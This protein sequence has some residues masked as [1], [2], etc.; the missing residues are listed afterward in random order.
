LYQEIAMFYLRRQI[1]IATVLLCSAPP[2]LQAQ[3]GIPPGE[4]DKLRELIRPQEG[5]SNWRRVD[6]LTSLHE[7]RLKAAAEGKPILLWSGGG[8]PPLGGC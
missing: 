7:A 3:D 2:A 6:W 5:E 8:A 4:F 1:L